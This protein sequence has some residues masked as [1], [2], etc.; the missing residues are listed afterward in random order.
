L[1][2]AHFE[3]VCALIRFVL[4]DTFSVDDGASRLAHSCLI[5][6]HVIKLST[7]HREVR[8]IVPVALKYL[9]RHFLVLFHLCNLFLALVSISEVFLCRGFRH[10]KVLLGQVRLAELVDELLSSLFSLSISLS[11]QGAGV[12]LKVVPVLGHAIECGGSK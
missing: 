6:T 7:A 4:F 9:R 12:V 11:I 8:I 10:F 1:L 5:L 3:I 2:K